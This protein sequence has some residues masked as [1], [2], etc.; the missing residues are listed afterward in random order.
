[1]AVFNIRLSSFIIRHS[2]FV[3]PGCLFVFVHN[4]LIKTMLYKLVVL[5][6]FLGLFKI[7]TWLIRKESETRN[8]Q[9]KEFVNTEYSHHQYGGSL[10]IYI[11]DLSRKLFSNLPDE[12]KIQGYEKKRGQPPKHFLEYYTYLQQSNESWGLKKLPSTQWIPDYLDTIF[13]EDFAAYE[14]QK[15]FD[16]HGWWD[17]RE[18]PLQI[19]CL[20]NSIKT[21]DDELMV[22]VQPFA[23]I[24]D[25]K[26]EALI[27]DQYV[28]ATNPLV[29]KENEKLISWRV[30]NPVT[31]EYANFNHK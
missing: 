29:L 18:Q 4:Q 10:F 11:K 27:N 3:N 2:S 28:V 5:T 21:V 12:V 24:T 15:L 1:M 6:L 25:V 20:V 17:S 13:L 9:E 23:L 14:I 16:N 8:T 26:I 19:K 7:N 30:L 22:D 31:N